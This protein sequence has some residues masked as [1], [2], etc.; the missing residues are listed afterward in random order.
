MAKIEKI[1]EKLNKQKVQYIL[2][3]GLATII[4]GVPRTTVD[5][6]IAIKP[7]I[8][9]I[10]KTI[11]A[12]KSLKLMPEISNQNEILLEGEVSFFNDIKVDILTKLKDTMFEEIWKNK[13]TITYNKV[14]INVI[15]LEDNIKLLKKVGR[16]Q[17]LEDIKILEGV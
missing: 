16:R 17:D 11:K 10:K 1:F 14:K 6:D 5:I 13:K 2:V 3:G 9:N 7:S 8:Q 4:Y 15:S 12:L